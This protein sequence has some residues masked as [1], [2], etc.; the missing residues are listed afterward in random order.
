MTES[1]LNR[2]QLRRWLLWY[3]LAN[4][5]ILVLLAQ[6]YPTIGYWPDALWP[7]IYWFIQ[8]FGHFVFLSFF[9][10]LPL[11]IC[12]WFCPSTRLIRILSIIFFTGLVVLIQIDVQIFALYRFHLNGVIWGFLSQGAAAEIFVFDPINFLVMLGAT[13]LVFITEILIAQLINKIINKHAFLYGRKL[14]IF[15]L[16][17]LI[18]GQL[19]HIRADARHD[20]SIL[21][22]V[23][24][25]PWPIAI[26]ARK[27]YPLSD[28]EATNIAHSAKTTQADFSL[29]YPKHKLSCNRDT[30]PLNIIFIVLD[31]WRFDMLSAQIS[32]NMYRF[33]QNAL[34]FENH[35]STGNA[36][37][38]GMFG[39]FSGMIGNYWHSALRNQS[40]SVLIQE[41][42]QRNY[43]FRFFASARLTSPE[44]DRTIF[45]DIKTQ[46]PE[47]TPGKK[48]IDRDRYITQQFIQFIEHQNR[49]KPFMSLIFY[50]APHAYAVDDN[51][52]QPFQPSLKEINY[53]K[54]N[55]ETPPLAFKNRYKNAI[56]FDDHLVGK[57]I[58]AL[59]KQQ[60]LD[61]SIVIITGDH[62]QEFNES[63]Q[64][65]WGH[66][67]N[68]SRYQVQVPLIIHW[69]DKQKK[70][71]SHTTSHVDIVPSLMQ[72]ALHCNNAMSDY[73]NGRSL[74]DTRRRDFVIASSW[75]NYAVIQNNQ[76]TVYQPLGIIE[77]YDGEYQPLNNAISP[78]DIS[79]AVLEE[80]SRFRKP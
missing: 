5:L 79:L 62:G 59:E 36:T 53:L 77:Q 35:I 30:P 9:L 3:S 22:M 55:N 52:P 24:L 10:A 73:S 71:Y 68:F 45:S 27:L 48:V 7:K 12:G 16:S 17:I 14:A 42:Q 56:Y 32:P 61:N 58:E 2:H 76:T 28:A 74:F 39:L 15:I 18:I 37:R 6:Q 54:L 69:P 51:F 46:I 57:L 19:W 72:E 31:S 26:T 66:N 34:V 67:S 50:D 23:S 70:H 38:F 75:S 65:Y 21:K 43:D 25:L 40:G 78:P 60:L 49:Q 29:F 33:S 80:L 41:L 8:S 64:N 1:A 20:V 47:K 13:L 63:R 44:F 11:L 4:A